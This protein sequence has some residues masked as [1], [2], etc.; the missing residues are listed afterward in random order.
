MSP[1]AL[2]RCAG[3][4]LLALAGLV[5]AETLFV[6]DMVNIGLHRE[7]DINSPITGLAPSGTALTVMARNGK[8]ARVQ[9]AGGPSGWIDGKYLVAEKPGR[10]RVRELETEAQGLRAEIARLR[11]E[12]AGKSGGAGAN[13]DA[14]RQLAER[15]NSER[16]KVGELTARMTELKSR[17]AAA[18]KRAAVIA[19]QGPAAGA[20]DGQIGLTN[21]KTLAIIAFIMLILGMLAGAYLLDWLN[22]R[23]HGGFRI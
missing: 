8:M 10:A 11:S 15:L 23:R 7:A 21:W 19:G 5:R 6:T 20:G 18:E 4:L 13:P 1:G 3:L 12:N 22:R 9:A 2:A 14:D 17:I 16:L